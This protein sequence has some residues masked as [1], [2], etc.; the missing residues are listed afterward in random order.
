MDAGKELALYVQIKI[1][2]TCH[3]HANKFIWSDLDELKVHF[4]CSSKVFGR[5]HKDLL[6]VDGGIFLEDCIIEIHHPP[7][8]FF[9]LTDLSDSC[10]DLVLDTTSFIFSRC[11]EAFW[12][13]YTSAEV[14]FKW[15]FVSRI[16]VEF[17]MSAI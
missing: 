3:F 14:E 16:F 6:R 4:R 11:R 8:C 12:I 7:E 9:I 13:I 10:K 1:E 17:F 5:A 2:G 15:P